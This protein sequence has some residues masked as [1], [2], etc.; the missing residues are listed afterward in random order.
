MVNP[1]SPIKVSKIIDKTGTNPMIKINRRL[2]KKN[3][4][5]LTYFETH[6]FKNGWISTSFFATFS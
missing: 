1:S 5:L 6:S 4:F 2:I 3:A